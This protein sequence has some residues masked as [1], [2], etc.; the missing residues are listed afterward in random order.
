MKVLVFYERLM[1]KNF[2]N[3]VEGIEKDGKET[4]PD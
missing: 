3:G 4:M 2:F 1:F